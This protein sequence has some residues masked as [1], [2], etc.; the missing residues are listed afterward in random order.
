[1]CF[2]GYQLSI[3][4]ITECWIYPNSEEYCCLFFNQVYIANKTVSIEK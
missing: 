2:S 1:M 3:S 4:L